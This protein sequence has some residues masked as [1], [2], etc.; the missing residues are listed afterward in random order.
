VIGAGEKKTKGS[1]QD[2][3]AQILVISVLKEL[4]VIEMKG[5]E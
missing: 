4:K 3:A 5:N 1:V 2:F